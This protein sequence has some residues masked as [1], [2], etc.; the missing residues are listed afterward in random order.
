MSNWQS[1]STN[2]V[3]VRVWFRLANTVEVRN[4]DELKVKEEASVG[5]TELR[6]HTHMWQIA[7]LL[8]TPVVQLT[9]TTTNRHG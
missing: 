8:I 9:N 6:P 3:E 1:G 7:E 5:S 4:I 2:L